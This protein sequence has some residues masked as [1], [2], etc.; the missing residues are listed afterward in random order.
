[1]DTMLLKQMLASP[2]T[3]SEL[4]VYD[5][6]Q[7]FDRKSLV[8]EVIGLA[9][10]S[11]E[12]PRNIL[13]GVNPGA[14]N[15]AKIVGIPD[16]AVVDLKRAHRLI[17]GLVEPL[18]D[19]A[20]IFDR[21]DGKLVGALEID[22]CEFGP[23]FL[24]QDL[25]DELRRGACWQRDGREL[26]AIDRRE[27]LNGHFQTNEDEE[28]VALPDNVQMSVGFNDDPDCEFIEITAPDSSNPP[29]ADEDA[30]GETSMTRTIA[31]TLKET[32]RLTTQMLNM[33][34]A[35][36]PSDDA[37]SEE[38][39]AGKE[40]AAAAR[41]HYFF[42]E[43]AAKVDLCIRNDCDT[44]ITDLAVEIGMPRIPGL[45]LADRIYTSPFDKRSA[46][47]RSKPNYPDVEH[48]D[49][50]IFVR[51]TIKSIAAN[52]TQPLLGTSLRFAVSSKALGKK[53]ALRYVL[54]AADGRRL[55][56]GRVKL[57]FNETPAE[58]ANDAS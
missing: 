13:F 10:A 4:L 47:A 6:F 11:V 12:G 32:V 21:I 41:K 15:G 50:A 38:D 44:N 3:S 8:R 9:N 30:S 55:S 58:A 27:L 33:A 26:V 48:R 52:D 25:S 36:E 24:A 35:D 22:G 45:D 49:D 51:T 17:S 18:L 2:T 20:F 37:S 53:L 28:P 54:R 40:I 19:L 31:Q 43:C 39:D 56:E 7:S 23:Y 34:K 57:R 16:S 46:N 5:V 29:F 14:V 1:M 42:E